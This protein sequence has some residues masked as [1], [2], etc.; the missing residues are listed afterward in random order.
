MHHENRWRKL[1]IR[2][3]LST[4]VDDKILHGEIYTDLR[5]CLS[6]LMSLLNESQMIYG[7]GHYS[8]NVRNRIY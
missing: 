5:K 7:P 2:R 8:Q 4:K 6:L 3:L 1:K